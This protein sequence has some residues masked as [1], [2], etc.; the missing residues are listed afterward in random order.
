MVSYTLMKCVLV[1]NSTVIYCTC[2][3]LYMIGF[4]HVLG[5]WLTWYQPVPTTSQDGYP[6][7]KNLEFHFSG[8]TS[9]SRAGKGLGVLQ[10]VIK[11]V[12]ACST[13]FSNGMYKTN[14]HIPTFSAQISVFQ[15]LLSF[16]SADTNHR[17]RKC[18]LPVSNG[19]HVKVIT[20]IPL[21][22]RY[23]SQADVNWGV[24]T[25]S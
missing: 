13:P 17:P 4:Y 21:I 7:I 18:K 19:L 23:Q 11:V 10:D 16:I 6:S 5:S 25:G 24:R 15:F 20:S 1:P 9:Y 22:F 2:S 8:F 14:I 12:S 3:S